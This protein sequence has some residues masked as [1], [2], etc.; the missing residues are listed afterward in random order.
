MPRSAARANLLSGETLIEWA[1]GAAWL[2]LLMLDPVCCT[3]VAASESLPSA[4][5]GSDAMEPPP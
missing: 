3:N 4:L 5:T 1:W 2:P